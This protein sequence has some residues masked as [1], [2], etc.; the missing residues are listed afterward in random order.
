MDRRRKN[1][2]CKEMFLLCDVIMSESRHTTVQLHWLATQPFNYDR[3]HLDIES[4]L[5]GADKWIG[6]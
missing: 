3:Q 5:N 6:R 4:N 2:E 1:L